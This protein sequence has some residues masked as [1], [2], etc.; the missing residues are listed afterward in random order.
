MAQAMA[1]AMMGEVSARRMPPWGA[2][3]TDECVPPL[4][5][6]DD[7]RLSN[8]EIQTLQRWEAAGAP[9]GDP[10]DAPVESDAIQSA[11]LATRSLELAPRDPYQPVPNTI[12]EFRC[13]SIEAPELEAGGFISAIHVVPGNRQIVHHVTVFAD[14]GGIASSRAGADGSFDCGPVSVTQQV[15]GVE[16]RLSWL[17]SWAPGGRPLELPSNLGI[18]LPPGSKL[19]MEVHYS[20]A[21]KAVEPDLTRVQIVKSPAAP[22][23]TVS[24]W[25]VGN[26]GAQGPTG[27]GLLPGPDDRD[28]VVEFRVPAGARAHVEEMLQTFDA[29]TPLP[30]FA[31]RAHAHLAAIDVK[32]DVLRDGVEQCLLQDRWDMH[33][34]R[35]YA[36]DAPV[37]GLPTIRAGDKVRVRCTFDNS[38]MNRRL[39][40]ELRYRGLPPMDIALGSNSLDEM[41]MVDL[42]YVR[43]TQ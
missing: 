12:D 14:V 22:E 15:S 34:Q 25:A 7:E 6:R 42:L 23:Y 1:P 40:P 39:G 10:R 3:D 33:W 2:Q 8:E 29:P 43:K 36:F 30:I 17:L 21:G 9:E 41:C 24:A 4:P 13:F 16:P 31:L 11:Q 32:V 38:M 28:G 27:D 37:E 35:V 19:L 5:W 20:T 26:L 18:E